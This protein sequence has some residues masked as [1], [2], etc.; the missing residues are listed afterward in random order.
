MDYLNLTK[1]ELIAIIE[2]Q[3]EQKNDPSRDLF[4]S[5]ISHDIRTL[6]NAIYGNV[7]ILKGSV[8]LNDNDKENINK[9]MESSTHLIDLINDIIDISKNDGEDKII[10]SEFNLNDF[11]TNIYSIFE[12]IA[13]SKNL[14]LILKNNCEKS[15]IIKYDKNKLFYT[16]LNLLS[17]A[18]KFTHKGSITIQTKY[19]KDLILFEIIDTGIGIKK[20][21]IPKILKNYVQVTSENKSKGTGL[22]LGIAVKN[23]KLLDSKLEIS[24]VYGKGST[25]SFVLKH[26]N[27]K[28]RYL[29]M[30]NDI[31][32]IKE[33]RKIIGKQNFDILIYSKDEDQLVILKNYFLLKNISYKIVLDIKD[34][35][36][37]ID[38]NKNQIVFIDTQNTIGFELDNLQ[39]LKKRFE[40]VIWVSLTASVMSKDLNLINENFTTY[41][42]KP[43]SYI[44][45]DQVLILFTK[46]QFEYIDTKVIE[47]KNSLIIDDNLK[48]DIIN[49]SMLCHYKN[50]FDL[51][52]TIDDQNTKKRLIDL[53]ENYDFDEIIMEIKK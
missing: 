9:I 7:Q 21:M 19:E 52:E 50:T 30:E 53:V 36:S 47:E 27:N 46:Q 44:D 6:L 42:V 12:S 43:Y 3:K 24:S 1:N 2:K 34:I 16:F 33:I 15:T 25:F 41:I 31:F 17:N 14:T 18:V 11:L 23:L 49:Q 29:S 35:E 13:S 37:L 26:I 45:I 4:I 40:K 39:K 51:I 28:K 32:S 38:A 48:Q 20:G 8:N 10:L 22:G 5:N